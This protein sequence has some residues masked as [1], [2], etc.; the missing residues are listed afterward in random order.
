MTQ[1]LL[2]LPA[3]DLPPDDPIGFQVGW[4]HAHHGLVPPAELL[5]EGTPIG[6]G[7]RA[8]RAVFA[9]RCWAATRHTRLWLALRIEAWRIGAPFDL[10][11][12]TPNHLAQ[13]EV[14]LCPVLRLPLGGTP[15]AKG[16]PQIARLNPR[17]A[18][19][20]GNL[21][22]LSRAAALAWQ[23]LDVADLVRRARAAERAAGLA[24]ATPGRE[25]LDPEDAKPGA[26]T[27]AEDIAEAMDAA[28]WWRLA[29]LRSLATPLRLSEAAALPM[30]VLPPNRTRV[31]NNVQ[32]LQALLTLRLTGSDWCARMNAIGGLLPEH[33]LRTDFNLWVGA[34]VPRLLEAQAHGRDAQRAL[35]D[36]WLA[37]R[38]M[39]RWQ[40]FALSLG[41]PAAEQLLRQLVA[42]PLAG[43]TA[44]WL[45]LD[46]ALDGWSLGAPGTRASPTTLLSEPAP[47]VLPSARSAPGTPP[48]PRADRRRTARAPSAPRLR[49]TEDLR[50]SAR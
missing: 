49:A 30:A 26:G 45:R 48:A 50:T 9:N 4:D 6:L 28:A 43:R 22:L 39:R 38:A 2:E 5:L 21:V 17:A 13:I 11:T 24:A 31:L 40:H 8:G 47:P 16:A 15:D 25:A 41:E 35:E 46:Q 1:T 12:V 23:G 14:R 29:T 44:R 37:E 32:G 20:A 19:A 10:Q 18:F 7:W 27:E 36:A 42:M 34:M 33:T 3:T